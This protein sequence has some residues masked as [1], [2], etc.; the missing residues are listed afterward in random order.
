MLKKQPD[1]EQLLKV[2]R[3]EP[4]E[5]PVL[6]EFIMNDGV[7][8]HLAGGD[9]CR[10]NDDLR[11]L[12]IGM[13]GFV[14]A[15]YDFAVIPPWHA[16]FM[17][18]PTAGHD[19]KSSYSIN[20]GGM[21]KD[22]QSF[23]Q[24]PWP[25]PENYDYDKISRLGREMPEGIKFL[26]CGYGGLLETAIA[27]TGFENL[28][29]MALM[30]EELTMAIFNEIGQRIFRYFDIVS[31]YTEVG[32]IIHA[33]DWGFKT[34]SMFPIDLMEKFVYPC[35]KRIADMIHAK[36]KPM[37]LHSCGYPVEV[38]DGIV[39]TIGYD[40]KHSYEDGI[41]PVEDAYERWHERVAILGGIDVDFMA[42]ST[43]EAIYQRAVKLIEQTQSRGGYALGSGNSIPPFIPTE[44]YLAML[45]A[46]G[47]YF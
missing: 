12:R 44:N 11:Q 7:L 16:G 37:I 9:V 42:R 29:M 14:N 20:E 24:Y 23:E 46:F 40:G 8:E 6:F 32:A 19:T 43:P 39:D 1:F 41:V 21:I 25:N 28:C 47:S 26:V 34:Q 4:T 13:H 22:W 45:R 2:L 10:C 33:D 30:D 5:K 36:G 27:L 17:N 35:H 31:S 38:M 3:R 15:G 18:F